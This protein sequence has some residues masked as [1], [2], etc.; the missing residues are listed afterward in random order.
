[1]L[2][3]LRTAWRHRLKLLGVALLTGT[4]VQAQ[5]VTLP[6]NDVADDRGALTYA[7]TNAT[8]VVD[9]Q[10][11][12]SNGTLLVRGAFVQ[13]AGRDVKVPA[14]AVVVDLKGKTVYPALLDVYSDYGVP[15]P[16]RGARPT[17][18]GQLE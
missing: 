4:W 7:F 1:M 18:R 14:G 5:T 8:L 9:P 13:A 2:T 12:I 3:P 16:K 6:R 10:T 17:F 15:E 11:T